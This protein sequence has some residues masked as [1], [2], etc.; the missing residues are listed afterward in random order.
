MPQHVQ[1]PA[2]DIAAGLLAGLLAIAAKW[3]IEVALENDPG[4]V[5]M[6]PAVAVAAWLR[7]VLA[8]AVATLV[9]AALDTIVFLTPV[10]S[11]G[12][13]APTD[14]L[15]LAA[16][17]I[18]GV[19]VSVLIHSLREGRA[20]V[21]EGLR[22]EV[23][24]NAALT[25]ARQRLD[26]AMAANR[27]GVWEWDIVTGSL[28]WSDAVAAQHGMPPGWAPP[29]LGAYLELIHPDDV[30]DFQAAVRASVEKR[31]AFSK[32]F[33]LV[34]PDGSVHW[35]AGAGRVFCDETGRPIRML[36]TGRDI[37]NQKRLEAERDGLLARERSRNQL[38]D[39]FLG[40]LS[41][42]LRTPVT[43]IYGMAK[44][45][46]KPDLTLDAETRR[47]MHG[48]IAEEAERVHRLV[49]D[50]LVLSR[51]E[52]GALR[53]DQDP[54]QVAH[55]ARRLARSGAT[56]TEGQSVLVR[57]LGDAL[58]LGEETYVEQVLRNFLSNAR[59]YGAG[60]AEVEI[61]A[62]DTEIEM[63]V[64]DRG[65]GFPAEEGARLFELFF[66]SESNAHMAAGSGVG[67]F[68]SATLAEAMGGRVWALPRKGGGAEFGLA[69]PR[70]EPVARPAK[71]AAA[72]RV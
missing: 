56:A 19:A 41:H 20:R 68:V 28:V 34:W 65:P 48:D 35:T 23:A 18:G 51:A 55:V 49:E 33:R 59:K 71:P 37:T 43:T 40:M 31:G 26:E 39:A 70:L 6:Y 30:E 60:A 27:A 25:D 46:A 50:L 42:E 5:L 16:F 53:P 67:L 36:G 63:R 44:M 22:Q 11:V 21:A 69:L 7:G 52:R 54:V 32:E 57:T 64:L 1:R 45:L 12:V 13:A 47:S 17:V 8:G 61:T 62:T 66:R 38:R 29:D 15:R 10:G 9:A 72:A 3:P 58:A 2:L 14:Q 24:L 4:F